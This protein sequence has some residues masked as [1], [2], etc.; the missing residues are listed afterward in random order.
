MGEL[1]GLIFLLG[2]LTGILVGVIVSIIKYNYMMHKGIIVLG[3]ESK[4]D[5]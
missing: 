4:V 1:M 2:F 5:E 3:E